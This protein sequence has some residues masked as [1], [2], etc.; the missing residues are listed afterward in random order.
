MFCL[1]FLVKKFDYLNVLH[2]ATLGDLEG[3]TF[4]VCFY[5]L[6]YDAFPVNPMLD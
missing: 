6:K 1:H 3:D 5:I 4:K 2:G